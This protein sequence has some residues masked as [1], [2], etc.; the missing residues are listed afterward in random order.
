MRADANRKAKKAEEYSVGDLMSLREERLQG[1][2][3]KI[4]LPYEGPY[5]VLTNEGNNEY[6][7][8]KVGEGVRL[9][10]QVHADRLIRYHDVME[11]D[12]RGVTVEASDEEE[13]EI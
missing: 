11:L 6:T 3:K 5:K 1:T 4:N 8:Q 10:M 13:K 2:G 9:K 12:K 7:I